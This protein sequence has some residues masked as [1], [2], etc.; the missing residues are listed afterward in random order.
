VPRSLVGWVLVL[1]SATSCGTQVTRLGARRP[2]RSAG[3]A[4]EIVPGTPPW[5]VVD[6]ALVRVKCIE[7]G[8]SDCFAG[9]R[10]QACA[11]GGDTAY[12]LAQSTQQ[13]VI[14]MTATLALRS[15]AGP[16]TPASPAGNA[17]AAACTPICSPGFDCRGGRCIPLCN[18]ACDPSE[19]CGAHRTCEPASAPAPPDA[20]A[21]P[22]G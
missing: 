12:G 15:P 18:P 13:H 3:C 8:P 16:P 9:L 21:V 17:R 14:S 5:P 22:P 10:A 20:A 2:A 4:V 6:L 1:A 7:T 19:I 11:A